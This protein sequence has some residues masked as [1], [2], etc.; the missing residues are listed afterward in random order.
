LLALS[1]HAIIRFSPAPTE[2]AVDYMLSVAANEGHIVTRK[3]VKALYECRQLDLRASLMELNFWCQFAIGDRRGGL[4]WFYLRWPQGC[5]V[6]EHGN[7]IRVVCDGAYEP[8]MGWICQDFLESS[9]PY[10]DIEE[11]TLHEAWDGWHLDAGDWQKNLDLTTWA[12]KVQGLS[13]GKRDDQAALQIYDDFTEAMSAA[14]LCS[15]RTFASENNILLDVTLPELSSK[16]REDYVVAYELL[17]AAPLI[18]HDTLSTDISLWMRSRARKYLQIDQ[19]VEH[20]WE[21]QSELD[22]P[23][24]EQ[25]I[26]HIRSQSIAIDSSITRHDFGSAFDPIS[27]PEK[28]SP[29]NTGSLE[30]SSFDRTM[31][32][33]ATE[34]A[35]YVRS[36]VSYDSR[37]QKDRARLS[38]LLSE[39]GRC[40]KRMRTTRAAMSALEGG[41]RSTTRRDRYF[42]PHLNPHLVLKTGLPSW[43]DAVL[44]EMAERGD[45]SRETSQGRVRG[46]QPGSRG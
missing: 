30:V 7:T 40:G 12:T 25:I 34:I 41:T 11:E 28:T 1:L 16:F 33:I 17:E 20:G 19:H 38:N 23:S 9:L 31:T 24:E 3:A 15:G 29:Y 45:L 22:R 39:G 44:V 21:V 46:G 8:G 14:D 18:S 27:E 36:I 37:L 10:L 42:G 4:E 6:D 43:Q 35:P 26:D 32:L 13:N 5:D 2:L